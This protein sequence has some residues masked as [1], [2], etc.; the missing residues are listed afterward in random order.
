MASKPGEQMPFDDVPF[1]LAWL[2]RRICAAV[3]QAV[4]LPSPLA[5]RVH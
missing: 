1:A 4:R 5:L 2:L 3:L